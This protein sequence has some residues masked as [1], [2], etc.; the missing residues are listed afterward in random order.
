[1]LNEHELAFLADWEESCDV[2]L[3]HSKYHQEL[4]WAGTGRKF[5]GDLVE[6]LGKTIIEIQGAVWVQGGHS[7]GTGITRDA[8]KSLLAL[9][10]GW[11][12]IAIPVGA[13]PKFMPLAIAVARSRIPR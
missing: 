11:V 10:N 2:A 6:P 13:F 9:S 8:F 7:T 12:T 4:P 5:R 1:M 3:Y